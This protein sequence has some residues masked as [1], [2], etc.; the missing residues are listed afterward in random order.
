MF[1]MKPGIWT[2]HVQQQNTQYKYTKG[3]VCCHRDKHIIDVVK[4][5]EQ[6]FRQIIIA[7]ATD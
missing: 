4:S 3:A 6:L 2:W 1:L 7:I 5:M